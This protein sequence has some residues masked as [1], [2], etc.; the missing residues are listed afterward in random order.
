MED[1]YL[2][3]LDVADFTQEDDETMLNRYLTFNIGDEI[4]G[5]EIMYVT[6]IIGMQKITKVPN[7]PEYIKGIINLR[8]IIYPVVEIRNRFGIE[9]VSYTEKTCIILVRVRNMGV[10]L[11]V[12]NVAEVMRI[13]PI[14]IF[15]PPQTYKGS[16][17]K[18]ISS[19]A[20]L[21]QDVKILLDLE[22]LLFEDA[23]INPDI[24]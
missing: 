24:N 17:S 10:G 22:K 15:P 12:D 18:Y 13:E 1:K 7:I 9:E 8:G 11:I 2:D 16:K 20:K 3:N 6:E 14:N 19:I 23:T 4:Y 21:D 5:F